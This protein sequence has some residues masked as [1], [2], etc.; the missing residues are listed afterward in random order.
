M[1]YTSLQVEPHPVFT[2]DG[3]DI[4]ADISIDLVDA[5]LGTRMRCALPTP[6][7]TFET[8]FSY[9]LE[10]AVRWSTVHHSD[11]WTVS[12]PAPHTTLP[13]NRITVDYLWS[14]GNTH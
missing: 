1:S 8:D 2:R 11:L 6:L 3:Y 7:F 5:I 9:H 12:V 4:E 13:I 14:S 10:F